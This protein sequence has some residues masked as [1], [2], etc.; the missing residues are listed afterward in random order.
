MLSPT[1]CSR[2]SVRCL[3]CGGGSGGSGG[4]GGRLAALPGSVA[5]EIDHLSPPAV[6]DS[7]TESR[8]L[9][10][11]EMAAGEAAVDGSPERRERARHAATAAA[12]FASKDAVV[13]TAP[14]GLFGLKVVAHPPRPGNIGLRR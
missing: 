3:V 9:V 14:G 7:L 11:C 6:F 12:V 2:L 5:L 1:N 8:T 13:R 10:S 4:G